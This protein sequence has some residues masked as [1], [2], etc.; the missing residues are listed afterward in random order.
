MKMKWD[1][2]PT[3]HKIPPLIDDGLPHILHLAARDV[4][5][6][7]FD[8]T[9]TPGLLQCGQFI[10]VFVPLTIISGHFCPITPSQG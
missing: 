2:A 1:N 9:L 7:A 3:P 6:I 8:Q 4:P 10:I 5:A